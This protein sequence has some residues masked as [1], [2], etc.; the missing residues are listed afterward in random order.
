ML[1]NR[2]VF[3][4]LTICLCLVYW[5]TSKLICF[6]FI[7]FYL[8]VRVVVWYCLLDIRCVWGILWGVN[9]YTWLTPWIHCIG[10]RFPFLWKIAFLSI[11]LHHK[12]IFVMILLQYLT[13]ICWVKLL[14]LKLCFTILRWVST[15]LRLVSTFIYHCLKEILLLFP[16]TLLLFYGFYWW[17]CLNNSILISG[18]DNWNWPWVWTYIRRL[19]VLLLF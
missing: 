5:C 10:M 4:T 6:Y 18:I 3:L 7:R 12:A 1:I 19:S 8:E 14:S 16:V 15:I 11:S 17:L 9:W 2:I 13:I